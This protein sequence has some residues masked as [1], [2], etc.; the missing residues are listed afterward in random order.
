[1]GSWHAGT[2]AAGKVPNAKLSAV[3]DHSSKRMAAHGEAKAFANASEMINSGEI[4]AILIATPHYSHVTIGIEA[5]NEGLHVLVEKPIA[6]HTADGERLIAAHQSPEQVFGAM[7]NQRTDPHYQKVRQLVQGGELGPVRRINW[8]VTDWFRTEAYYGSSDWRATW[9][10]EGG[11]V[12]LNQCVHNIDLLQWIFGLPERV[13]SFCQLG[14]YHKIEVEDSVAAILEFADGTLAT[15]STSTGEAPGTNRLEIAAENGRLVLEDG[16]IEW[17]RNEV[18][19]SQF[20]K[21][22]PEG[23]LRPP[24]WKVEVPLAADRGGQHLGILKNFTRAI[25]HGDPLLA[26]AAEGLCSVELLNA[27]LWASI[28]DSTITLPIDGRKF[29]KVLRK[30]AKQS[31]LRAT[32]EEARDSWSKS[33]DFGP[34]SRPTTK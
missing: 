9:A 17:M 23:Y 18:P 6:V 3:C 13:R 33:H 4:D 12:L 11:G 5:L 15:F 1:M 16:R 34:S 20:S 7:F 14:Q 26:P 2:L 27:I 30:L 29:E 24:T 19:M 25:T 8:T 10:G 22:C 21:E 28:S 31:S 32:D